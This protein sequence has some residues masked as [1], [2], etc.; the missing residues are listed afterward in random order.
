MESAPRPAS[1]ARTAFLEK[2]RENWRN[3]A[4]SDDKRQKVSAVYGGGP[5]VEDE[6][7]EGYL[8][9]ETFDEQLV[10]EIDEETWTPEQESEAKW[11]HLTDV[12]DAN[13]SYV[14][15]PEAE[16][17]GGIKLTV[18]WV[19]AIRDSL[20]KA[21]LCARDFASDKRDD[22][23]APGA[24]SL[25]NRVIDLKAV[26]NGLCTYTVDVTAAYNTLD[27][28][29][30][31]YVRPPKEWLDHRA[32]QGLDTKVRWRMLRLLP[33]RRVAA[34]IWVEH[35]GQIHKDIGFVQNEAFGQ[36]F[37]HPKKNVTCEIHMD[38]IHGCGPTKIVEGIVAQM[39][40]KLKLKKAEVHE[41]NSY[42]QHLKRYRH[43]VLDGRL[44]RA[45][46]SHVLVV[47][48]RLGLETAK[49]A[50]VP[51]SEALRPSVEDS[52]EPLDDEWKS[53]YRSLVMTLLYASLDIAEVQFALR[54]LTTDMQ[55]PSMKS[56]ER[57]KKVTKYLK[58][59]VDEGVWFPAV[60]KP[61]VLRV[62]T[63]SD[64]AGDR[65]TRKSTTCIVIQCGNCTLY[66]ASVGQS[67]H[68]Q[69]SG[70][71]EFYAAVSGMQ[72]ALGLHYL[73]GS[74]GMPTTIELQLDSAAARGVLWRSGIGKYDTW[75]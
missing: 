34:K 39:H 61:N 38:D 71:A 21:R 59:V 3:V 44:I 41:A 19:M 51:L 25:T 15:V 58:G 47:A 9:G 49:C 46:P 1:Q 16:A 7:L 54:S 28:P 26:K 5:V 24:T 65:R 10:E 45:N 27:E 69:S 43:V 50:T 20:L 36:F 11:R 23:F 48:K 72:A 42:Y 18:T 53:E 75:K 74:I 68:S 64:W 33:G 12:I 13:D 40:T 60:G 37:H 14:V 29:E 35:L 6:M 22:L 8:S 70:E 66:T 55:A 30:L 73:L 31:V 17:V 62:S 52:E 4:D 56:W 57:L 67:I 63:D 32:S 2:E